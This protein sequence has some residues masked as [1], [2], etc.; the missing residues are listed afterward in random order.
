MFI[1]VPFLLVILVV[2][3]WAIFSGIVGVFSGRPAKVDQR[4]IPDI[5]A[6]LKQ[7]RPKNISLFSPDELRRPL[8]RK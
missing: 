4:R 6:F 1:I 2:A 5:M 3:V 7:R 8:I